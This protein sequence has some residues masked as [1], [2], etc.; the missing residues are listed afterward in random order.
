MNTVFLS[1]N[2]NLLMFLNLKSYPPL[3]S[4]VS[5]FCG[6]RRNPN[7]RLRLSARFSSLAAVTATVTEE[8]SRQAPSK[9][10]A[11][12]LILLRH[13]KSSWDNPSLRGEKLLRSAQFLTY[14]FQYDCNRSPFSFFPISF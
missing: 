1:I 9:S 13:A 11:R 4:S 3:Q 6:C 8:D 5:V 10:M 12:R 2:S 7:A 14:V